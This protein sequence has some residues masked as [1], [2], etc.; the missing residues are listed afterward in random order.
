M[1]LQGR[2]GRTAKFAPEQKLA[3]TTAPTME[4]SLLDLVVFKRSLL[5]LV[6]FKAT[7]WRCHEFDMGSDHGAVYGCIDATPVHDSTTWMAPRFANA[8]FVQVFVFLQGDMQQRSFIRLLLSGKTIQDLCRLNVI[9]DDGMRRQHSRWSN[10]P[11]MISQSF[12]WFGFG[13]VVPPCH[14]AASMFA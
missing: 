14:T 4:R 6:V 1:W 13:N 9:Q 2:W 3:Y 11:L 7:P 12:W 5:D 10:Q 8:E